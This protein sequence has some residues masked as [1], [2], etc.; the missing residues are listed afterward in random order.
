MVAKD[1][2]KDSNLITLPRI[3]QDPTHQTTQM[4]R[5]FILL[6]LLHKQTFSAV[7]RERHRWLS[8]SY[9]IRAPSRALPYG[10]WGFIHLSHLLHLCSSE[11]EVTFGMTHWGPAESWSA[12]LIIEYIKI[13]FGL[14]FALNQSYCIYSN[15]KEIEWL[16][17]VS[18]TTFT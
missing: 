17:M 3:A 18:M 8:R 5:F 13:I 7:L 10:Q 12:F 11:Q 2:E 6:I 16:C 1:T 14:V 9:V 4:R 15:S